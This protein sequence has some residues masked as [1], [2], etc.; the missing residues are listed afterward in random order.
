MTAIRL[1]PAL[2]LAAGVALAFKVSGLASAPWGVIL[3]AHA[4]ANAGAPAET[5]HE[6]PVGDKAAA[7]ELPAK[8]S[9]AARPIEMAAAQTPG[10]ATSAGEADVLRSLS[11]RREA[12]NARE[13]ELAV[14]EQTLAVA[15]KR[16]E[17]RVVELKAIEAR[18]NAAL[19]QREA[20]HQEQIQSLIKMYESMKPG[21]AA[22]IFEKMGG[23]I[24]V[25]VSSKMKPVKLG[26]IL[27]FMDPGKA[28]DL[29]VLLANRLNPDQIL[30]GLPAAPA[31]TAIVPPPASAPAP[32]P[33][34][35]VAPAALQPDV[36]PQAN[37]AAAPAAPLPPDTLPNAP[38][39]MAAPAA[40]VAANS[41]AAPTAAPPVPAAPGKS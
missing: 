37:A 14:R 6:T 12:L 30:G 2:A 29:T 39:A 32:K 20:A 17:E 3:D 40:P 36:L 15:E 16:V 34:A 41:N 23:E 24:L 18:I 11:A 28:Q 1:L 19:G 26:A 7:P 10:D 38:A 27:A 25:S 31:E 33:E 4:A 21:D 22:K 35:A 9:E 5:P 13:R 8:G